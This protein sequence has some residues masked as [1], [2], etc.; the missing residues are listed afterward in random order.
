MNGAYPLSN[1]FKRGDVVEVKSPREILATLD[2]VGKLDALPFMPEMLQYCGRRFVVDRRAEKICDT[3]RYSGSRRLRNTV[4]VEDLRCDGS[5]HDGCQADCR[6]FWKESW[7]RLVE[8]NEPLSSKHYV[9][10]DFRALHEVTSRYVKRTT[11]V[12]GKT[13]E[14]YRCQA[15]ELLNATTRLKLWDPIPYIREFTCGNVPFGKFLRISVKAF[16]I[17]PL[18]ILGFF[19]HVFLKGS[20]SGPKPEDELNLQPG[21][22]VQVKTLDEIVRLLSPVGT[23]RGLWFDREMVPYCGGTFQVR[24]R[25]KRFIH[26][27]DGR[28]I[29]LKR[30]CVTLEGAV[31]SG[32]LSMRRW[33]C[34]RRI[35]PFW[36]ESWL[37]RV[38]VESPSS[39]TDQIQKQST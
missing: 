26:D 33:F 32:E 10:D 8:P 3:I 36:R 5:G 13:V 16:F 14:V 12:E 22:W 38:N 15:T 20:H 1:T 39:S 30:E 35:Y 31:C 19:P 6:L 9:D 7:L 34:A 28:M 4:L 17:E 11:E 21:D 25:I 2:D 29:E 27:A 18:R 37:R 24:Q 23:T